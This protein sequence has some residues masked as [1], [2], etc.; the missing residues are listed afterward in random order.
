MSRPWTRIL[1][2][3]SVL[4]VAIVAAIV[5]FNHMSELAHRSGEEWRANL[6]PLSV[7]GMLV[8]ATLAIVDRRRARQPAGW[9]PWVGLG[10]GLVASLG[11]NIAAARPE[12]IAQLVAA[13]PP[14]AL[15]VSIETLVVVLRNT[16]TKVTS[17][18]SAPPAVADPK[19]SV[20]VAPKIQARAK[21]VGSDDLTAKRA[22]AAARKAEYRARKR[23]QVNG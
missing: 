22:K 11:A 5:S 2:V 6:L 4:L 16:T 9:V 12:L 10:L 19:T 1:T 21:R 8:A 15:A 13:W 14:V 7:D 20:T 18:A 3:A 17:R 23:S